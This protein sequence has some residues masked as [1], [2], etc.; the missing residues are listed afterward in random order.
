MPALLGVQLPL[1]DEGV[2][3][4]L[5]RQALCAGAAGDTLPLPTTQADCT[6]DFPRREGV[7]AEIELLRQFGL[8]FPW[9]CTE[10]SLVN[11]SYP[12]MCEACD[13]DNPQF[14]LAC[15]K[16]SNILV[17]SSDV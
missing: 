10:C 17:R 14:D 6:A 2:S 16:R 7:A 15:C 13:K 3:N 12:S 1:P 8:E 9:T 11:E 4:W 5:P